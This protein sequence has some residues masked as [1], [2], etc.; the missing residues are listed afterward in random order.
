MQIET[1]YEKRAVLS[2]IQSK[3]AELKQQ[4]KEI[5]NTRILR[6]ISKTPEYNREKQRI[7]REK[8]LEK[9]REMKKLSNW[10]ARGGPP[11]PKIKV[12]VP[13]PT[14]KERPARISP[15]IHESDFR[16]NK[17]PLIEVSLCMNCYR[18]YLTKLHC[19]WCNN[20]YG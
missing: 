1:V 6:R 9:S 5:E 13:K 12:F 8:N 15:S 3:I 4:K 7:W 11:K 16:E 14:P 2:D 10:K 20:I 17:E 19:L 18:K